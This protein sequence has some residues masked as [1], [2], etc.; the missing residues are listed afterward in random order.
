MREIIKLNQISKVYNH[1]QILDQ[2]DLSIYTKG[3][4]LRL[5]GITAAEKAPCSK[6]SP[7]L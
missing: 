7:G 2:V 3:S 6:L 5:R 1:K 4:P